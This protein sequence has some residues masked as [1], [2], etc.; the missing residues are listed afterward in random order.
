MSEVVRVTRSLKAT[1]QDVYDAWTDADRLQ[2][3]LC[4]GPG[5]VAEASCDPVVG[6][7]YRIVKILDWGA[8]EVTGEY[9]VVEPPHRLVFTWTADTT[10]GRA[11]QVSVT[12]RPDGDTTEM[13]IVHERLPD[14]GRREGAA[15]AWAD[16]AG[17]L[18]RLLARQPGPGR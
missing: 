7:R 16:L 5:F 13:T 2:Q 11:T 10:G 14:R 9:L 18:E 12:L 4:P 17:K 3:W 15:A 8:D 6:G 1:A